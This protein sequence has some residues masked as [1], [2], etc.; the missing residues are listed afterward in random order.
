MIRI[1]KANIPIVILYGPPMCGKTMTLIRLC[2]YLRVKGYVIEPCKE[3]RSHPHYEEN[4][5]SFI[6]AI[7]SAEAQPANGSYDDMFVEIFDK[8]GHLV[9][10]IYDASG[11]YYMNPKNLP[12]WILALFMSI[13]PK[14]WCFYTEPDYADL[15]I[16]H[17]YVQ[18]IDFVYHQFA[19]PLRDKIII[20]HNKIDNT[21]FMISYQHV[22]VASTRQSVRTLYPY[23]FDIFRNTSF[24]KK[25]F[26]PYVFTFVPFMTG[27]FAID[28]DEYGYR[29]EVYLLGPDNYPANLWNAIK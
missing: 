23:L 11:D 19:N 17:E 28:K 2:R 15:Q 21:P 6:K 20:I 1:P 7:Y 10:Y 29:H 24:I 13:N 16:R 9:C 26:K 8:R 18:T 12:P 25:W 14:I 22:D 27:K 5:C 3:F 4:C